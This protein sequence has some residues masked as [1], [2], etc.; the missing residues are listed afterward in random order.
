M[1]FIKKILSFLQN[2]KERNGL[3]T[4]EHQVAEDGSP[5]IITIHTDGEG[6]VIMTIFTPEEW[7]MVINVAE[8]TSESIIEIVAEIAEDNNVAT[9]TFDPKDFH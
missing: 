6:M 1:D 5:R 3:I 7:Q 9:I 2:K 4:F 8:L